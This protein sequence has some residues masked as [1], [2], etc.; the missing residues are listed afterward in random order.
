MLGM[1]ERREMDK[2]AI[3]K[4]QEILHENRW[5]IWVN[6]EGNRPDGGRYPGGYWVPW[7]LADLLL[8][9]LKDDDPNAGVTGA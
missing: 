3:K 4:A 7:H 2:D 5:D 9:S 8:A 1:H 6:K